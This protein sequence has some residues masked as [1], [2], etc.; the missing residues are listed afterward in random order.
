[1]K[2]R[3]LR[4]ACSVVC[5]IA[6]V[7]LIALWLRSYW[8]TD[9]LQGPILWPSGFSLTSETGC[10]AI[11]GGDEQEPITKWDLSSLELDSLSVSRYLPE[12]VQFQLPVFA[13]HPSID[14]SAYIRVPHWFLAQIFAF[15]AF[16][17]TNRRRYSL[18]TLLIVVTLIA[19][20]LG[21]IAYYIVHAPE[22]GFGGGSMGGLADHSPNPHQRIVAQI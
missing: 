22:P 1:M 4:I 17:F 2:F 7:L 5:S 18:R 6:C 21:G 20:E 16:A 13:F 15:L 19:L 12:T 3:T 9:D 10:L 14:A 8:R 11:G